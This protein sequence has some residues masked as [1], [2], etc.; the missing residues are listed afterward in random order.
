V[1]REDDILQDINNE[2]GPPWESARPQHIQIQDSGYGPGPPRGQAGP[3]GW[4]PDP[5]YGVRAAHSGILGLWDR[6]YP[7]LN[8][9]QARVRSRHMFGLYR[10]RFRSS[11]RRRPD[12]ATWPT[13]RDVSQRAEPDVRPLGRAASAFIADEAHRLSIPLAGDVPPRH[14]MS[15][16]H[17]TGRRCAA[18][19]FNE[20]C[21]SAG[22]RR[23]DH[24]AGG[25]RVH[26]IGRRHVHTTACATLI[27]T[28]ALP[29][30]QPRHINIVWTSDIMALGD[31]PGD[32][33][34]SYFLPFCPWAHMSG[35]NILVRAPLEL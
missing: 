23:L 5:L 35:L 4:D 22:R 10:I 25:V 27:M 7:G 3:L 20:P 16:V 15:P 32:T 28:R 18:S 26:S 21:H 6:E 30:K 2:S 17:S 33:G 9:G 24:P 19:A 14:L 11:P 31:R 8:Q 29:R 13:A 34:I 1:G 12:A